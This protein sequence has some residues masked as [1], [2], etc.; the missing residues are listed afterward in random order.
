MALVA[1]IAGTELAGSVSGILLTVSWIGIVVVPIV[2]GVI[3]NH[4]SYTWCWILSGI[5][6][7]VGVISYT[8]FLVRQ[9]RRSMLH[10]K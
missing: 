5:F 9:Q 7:A 6:A 8:V 10:E 4:W 3:S 1:E 2:Y